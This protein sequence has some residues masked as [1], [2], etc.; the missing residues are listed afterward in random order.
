M[1]ISTILGE[2]EIENTL[3][4]ASFFYDNIATPILSIAAISIGIIELPLFRRIY[5][6]PSTG[7]VRALTI[8]IPEMKS[9]L[10]TL[11]VSERL[12]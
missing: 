6:V 2:G 4:L 7:R 9:I 5:S 10:F 8:T 11:C 3:F 1:F 12:I